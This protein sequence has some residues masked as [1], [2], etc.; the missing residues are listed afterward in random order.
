MNY[1]IP[2]IG[3]MG[4]KLYIV[5]CAFAEILIYFAISKT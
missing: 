4:M 2:L 5:Y 3:I 1:T